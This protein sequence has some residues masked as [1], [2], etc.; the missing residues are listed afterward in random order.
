[1]PDKRLAW[2]DLVRLTSDEDR[3][4]RSRAASVLSSVFS[5]VQDKQLAWNDLHR[6]ISN[7]DSNVRSR[8]ASAIGFAFFEAPDKQLAWSDLVTLT[9]DEDSSVK[10]YANHSLGK[11][12]IFEASQAETDEGYKKELRKAIEFF[13]IAALASKYFNPSQFCLPF[14]R[15]FYTIVFKKQETKAEVD[16]YLADAKDAVKG[17][18]SKELLFEAVENLATALKEVQSIENLDLEAKKGELNFYRK[19]CDRA[20]ELMRDTEETAPYTTELMRKGLPI[21]D[22]SLKKLLEEIQKKAKTACKESQGTATEEIACVINREVQKWEI[23]N[24]EEMARLIEYLAYLLKNK[25]ANL[26]EKEFTLEKIDLML[27]EKDLTKKFQYLNYIIG[28]LPGGDQVS[29]KNY[30]NANTVITDP[31]DSNISISGDVNIPRNIPES[32]KFHRISKL[33]FEYQKEIFT[34]AIGSLIGALLFM[35]LQKRYFP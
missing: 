19:Y 21:L 30:I 35:I 11:V 1:M 15:S 31:K 3:F 18:K 27:N 2:N 23:S 9:S 13:E 14:Y 4:V 8:A 17:S 33:I 34:G 16:K 25:V 32:P 5:D 28:S 29:I 12:S 7:K 22:R 6:L 10:V 24:P 20:A 26:P